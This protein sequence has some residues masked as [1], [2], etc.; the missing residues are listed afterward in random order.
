[1]DEAARCRLFSVGFSARGPFAFEIATRFFFSNI[2]ARLRLIKAAITRGQDWFGRSEF[3][4]GVS[5]KPRKVDFD[6]FHQ[7][8]E[9]ENCYGP[10]NKADLSDDPKQVSFPWGGPG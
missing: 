9:A 1:M 2:R 6:L 7:S 4:I 3:F 8:A 5:I 10:F